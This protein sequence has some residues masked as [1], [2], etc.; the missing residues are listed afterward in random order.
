V[1]KESIDHWFSGDQKAVAILESL[2]I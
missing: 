1:D 2:K